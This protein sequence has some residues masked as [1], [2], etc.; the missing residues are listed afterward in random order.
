VTIV[1]GVEAVREAE[2]H[3]HVAVRGPVLALV[4]GALASDGD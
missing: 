1:V 2:G 3:R 4:P